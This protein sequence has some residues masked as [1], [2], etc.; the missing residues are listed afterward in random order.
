MSIDW[1]EHD[2][3]IRRIET[4]TADYV[5][6]LEE[7]FLDSWPDLFTDPCLYLLTT[8]DAWCRGYPAGIMRCTSRGM[9]Q[10]RIGALKHANIYEPQVYRHVTGPCRLLESNK[11]EI[12]AETCFHAARI[13]QTGETTLFAT[14]V[15]RDRIVEENGRWRFKEKLVICDSVRI[16]VLVAIPL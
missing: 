8:R 5:H 10:D 6:S 3:A 2:R 4:L 11:G 1:D 14:G 7:E 9:L 16:D 12:L 15:Y 13:M